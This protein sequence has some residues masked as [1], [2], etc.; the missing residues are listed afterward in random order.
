MA[1]FTSPAGS[2][3]QPPEEHFGKGFSKAVPVLLPQTELSLDSDQRLAAGTPRFNSFQGS[4]V[5]HVT[6]PALSPS[7]GSQQPRSYF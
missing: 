2:K 7:Q 3:H 6:F 5:P 4:Q 1:R